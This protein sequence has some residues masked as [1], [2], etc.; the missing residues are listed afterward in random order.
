[1]KRIMKKIVWI[2]IILVVIAGGGYGAYILTRT[3]APLHPPAAKVPEVNSPTIQPLVS[4]KLAMANGQAYLADSNG[5]TLYYFA[6]DEPG[7]SNCPPGP[8]L[9]LWPA[10]SGETMSVESPLSAADFSVITR[11]GG[12]LQIA[13]K[14]WPLYYFANDKK[15][16]DVLG[17][18]SLGVWF[19]VPLPFYTTLVENSSAANGSYL[20]DAAGRAL[21]A[22][23]NDT[24]GTPTSP[25]VSACIDACAALWPPFYID[26]IILPALLSPNDVTVIA[27]PDG[28]KQIAYKGHPLYYYSGDAGSGDVKGKAVDPAWS[29]VTP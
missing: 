5:M 8:C 27:R 25:A 12:A 11:P 20:A 1:M 29:L 26:K 14:G 16:G 3:S 7:T 22:S 6:K 13:Y 4:V 19:I 18:G 21:Y 23:K 15:P 28:S 24:I 17:Q 10:F 2:V 9:E